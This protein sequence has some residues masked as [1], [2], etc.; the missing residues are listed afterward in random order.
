MGFTV[1]GVVAWYDR[2][3]CSDGIIRGVYLLKCVDENGRHFTTWSLKKDF[4]DW[5][6]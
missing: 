1:V 3:C 5:T 2:W 6:E 4:I